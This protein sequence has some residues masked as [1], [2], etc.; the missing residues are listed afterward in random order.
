MRRSRTLVS[1][2]ALSFVLSACGSSSS[3]SG[4]DSSAQGQEGVLAPY[5]ASKAGGTLTLVAKGAAGTLD[6]HINYTLQFWQLYQ[7][8][9]DGL[10]AFRKVD[11]PKS[12]ET[13]PDLA[14]ALPELSDGGKTL[15][16]T[17]RKGIKFSDGREVTVN[18]VK[19][20]FERIFKVSSPTAGG[21][22]NGIVGAD[23]CFAKPATCKL[24]QGVNVY[25]AT[26]KI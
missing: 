5:D 16:F 7:A 20:S 11:G 26:N 22:Y 10:L 4:S 14:E 9:Y 17:L 12:F 21:F 6:P 2:I 25:P 24:D 8:T 23:S 18:D 3:D 19:A 15:T 13:V 1:L